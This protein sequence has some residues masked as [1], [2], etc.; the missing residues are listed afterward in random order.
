M[1]SIITRWSIIDTKEN[2]VN[3]KD[4][5][6]IC[7]SDNCPNTKL[8]IFRDKYNDWVIGEV[9]EV[10]TNK[11]HKDFWYIA[12]LAVENYYIYSIINTKHFYIEDE[13]VYKKFYKDKHFGYVIVC[14]DCSAYF[15]GTKTLCK[16]VFTKDKLDKDEYEIWTIE[17][18]REYRDKI[19]K[20]YDV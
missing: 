1:K 8:I 18:Y 6:Y 10:N 7:V 13:Y 20:A 16:K 19:S 14:C 15:C 2:A 5:A 17:E 3:G 11:N 4:T 9:T 12:D